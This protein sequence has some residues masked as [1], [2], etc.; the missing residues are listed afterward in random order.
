[1][2]SLP[3]V[4]I[5]TVGQYINSALQAA[6]SNTLSNGSMLR[7]VGTIGEIRKSS[8]NTIYGVRL[9]DNSAMVLIDIPRSL[10]VS[11]NLRGGECVMVTGT[12]GARM[13]QQGNIDARIAVS[14]I[15]VRGNH[16][17]ETNANDRATITGLKQLGMHRYPFPATSRPSISLISS[18]SS[19]A[20]VDN[21]FLMELG[22]IA[23]DLQI[24]RQS[25]NM[26]SADEIASAINRAEGEIIVLIRGGG[27]TDQFLVFENDK[28][29]KALATKNAYRIV[30]LGHTG[31]STILD[32]VADFSANTPT[33]AGGHIKDRIARDSQI[34]GDFAVQNTLLA[35]Q[36]R[37]RDAYIR[38][39]QEKGRHK[40]SSPFFNKFVRIATVIGVW[41]GVFSFILFVFNR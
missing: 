6:V 19:N 15:V 14:D 24:S 5:A 32:L 26:Q 35:S 7:V 21:D 17:N 34:A 11:K 22:I 25:I 28:V 12:I 18:R 38:K 3:V 36:I 37:E 29:V 16:V 9:I 30:G 2:N 20:Q 41:I 31:N 13:N 39:M 40:D 4:S 1:M 10:V 23:Q 33:Q 27:D 8:Y